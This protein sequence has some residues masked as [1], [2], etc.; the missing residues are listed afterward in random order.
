MSWILPA[1]QVGT[2]IYGAYKSGRDAKKASLQPNIQAINRNY[3]GQ[4]P[5]AVVTPEDA[6]QIERTR[7]A[8]NQSAARSAELSRY[9]VLHSARARGLSGASAAAL[10]S[11]VDQQQARD[12]EQNALAAANQTYQTGANARQFGREKLMTAWG[13]EIGGAQQAATQ[14][15]AQNST[16]WN[17]IL[18]GMPALMAAF[19]PAPKV[20]TSL[21]PNVYG[22]TN[23]TPATPR[24]G[25]YQPLVP[26]APASVPPL[27]F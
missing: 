20:S 26:S 15:N 17:S 16:M 1:I 27:R 3:M 5:G 24:G 22:G 2:S 19:S 13:N 4:N 25:N 7:M 8:G 12:R 21:D 11:E 6:A 23:P 9:S 10:E 18:E 14:A